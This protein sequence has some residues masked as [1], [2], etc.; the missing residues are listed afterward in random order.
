M[1]R[2]D[3][4]PRAALIAALV[5]AIGA[6][7]AI[8]AVAAIRRA[9]Q[10]PVALPAVPAPQA[11][12]SP[13]RALLDALP[14]R[15]GDFQRAPIAEPAPAGTAAWR[16]GSGGEPVVLRCGLERPADFVVGS[17]VQAVDR[18]QWF[19]EAADPRSASPSGRSTWYTVDRPVYIALT[20][21]PGSGPT[22]IQQVS[23]LIERTV[24]AVPIRPAPARG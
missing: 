23:D 6:V 3:G 20:L 1:A 19:R 8:L 14:Q 17:P 18:V 7:G 12:D 11:Q 16:T 5:L 10:Q 9:P 22:P 15:L 13:C 4:P 2:S 21:P 24:E